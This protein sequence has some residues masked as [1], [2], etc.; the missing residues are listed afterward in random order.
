MIEVENQLEKFGNF[1]QRNVLLA[2]PWQKI[3]HEPQRLFS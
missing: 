3:F 2:V 1:V